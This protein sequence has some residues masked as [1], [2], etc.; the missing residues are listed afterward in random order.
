MFMLFCWHSRTNSTLFVLKTLLWRARERSTQTNSL[1]TS[2]RTNK[3]KPTKYFVILLLFPTF[4]FLCLRNYCSA[5][6]RGWV[7]L[8]HRTS[9]E[10]GIWFFQRMSSLYHASNCCLSIEVYYGNN[11][12]KKRYFDFCT[13]S[14]L[15][16]HHANGREKN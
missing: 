11:W 3:T 16:R 7:T 14:M 15:S 5:S 2:E 9:V 6:M 8:F 10:R 1:T 13:L 4:F 12:E